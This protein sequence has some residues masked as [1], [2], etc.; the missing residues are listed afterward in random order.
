MKDNPKVLGRSL[1]QVKSWGIIQCKIRD[2]KF[3]EQLAKDL[4][5]IKLES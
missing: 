2:N 4:K 5:P 3:K 1:R